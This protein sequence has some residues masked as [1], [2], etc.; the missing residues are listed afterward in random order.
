MRMRRS[1]RSGRRRGSGCGLGQR[2]RCRL[3]VVSDDSFWRE[4]VAERMGVDVRYEGHGESVPE[5]GN[6]GD[7]KGQC[8]AQ[9]TAAGDQGREEREDLK[10]ERHEQKDPSEAPH[11]EVVKGRGVAAMGAAETRRDI[12][13]V[14]VPGE[15]KGDGGMG[16]AA[17]LVATAADEE[18]GPLGDVAGAGDAAG[19]GAEVVRLAEGGVVCDAGEDEEPDEEEGSGEKGEAGGA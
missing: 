11:E 3:Q 1:G 18:V 12:L 7:D 19:V 13:G 2:W 15:A 6:G 8:G 14:T 16:I 5:E 9:T 10:E 17:V 4:A